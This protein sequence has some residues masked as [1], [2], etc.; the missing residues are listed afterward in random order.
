[1]ADLARGY[2][3]RLGPIDYWTAWSSPVPTQD[4]GVGEIADPKTRAEL[5]RLLEHAKQQFRERSDWEGDIRQ[6]PFFAGL[7]KDDNTGDVIVGLKQDNNGTVYV[8]A[9][10][11]LSWLREGLVE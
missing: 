4:E 7:P 1:M 6:G 3:Y 11:E 5:E 10:I 8:W 9:P 2:V